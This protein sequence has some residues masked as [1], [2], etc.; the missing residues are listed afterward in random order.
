MPKLLKN[1]TYLG[2]Q[3]PTHTG[4]SARVFLLAIASFLLGAGAT[5]LLLHRGRTQTPA[6]EAQSQ[7]VLS[8]TTRSVLGQ[9]KSPVELRFYAVLDPTTVSASVQAFA[10]RVEN[11]VAEYERE[12]NGKIQVARY[13]S[14]SYTNA[15]AAVHDG[16]KAFN[17]EKGEACFLGIALVLKDHRESLSQLSPEWEPVLESDLTRA[18]ARLLES[19]RTPPPPPAVAQTES[20]A[21][22]EVK[23]VIPDVNAVSLQ[24]GTRLLRAAALKEFQNLAKEAETR[25]K[26]A[27]QKLADAQA[28]KSEAEQQAARKKLQQ[29]QAEE[30]EKLKEL[31][32][33][34]QAQVEAF[35]RLKSG[36][37]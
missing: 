13:E 11:V 6:G 20:N 36:A 34:S 17:A 18:L 1:R 10:K 19:T 32:A 30:T 26:E 16:I 14:Q 28:G 7:V 9:I 21:V 4:G 8:E 35:E 2:T 27:Q 15:N 29:I 3:R 5:G 31:A 22:Q 37:Q 25:I 24:D 33:R 12:A 23:A